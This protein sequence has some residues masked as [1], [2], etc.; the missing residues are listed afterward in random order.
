MKYLYTFII[1]L[2]ANLMFGQKLYLET[3][4]SRQSIKTWSLKNNGVVRQSDNFT[5]SGS[6]FIKSTKDSFLVFND[7]T[8]NWQYS[9]N[10]SK[11]FKAVSFESISFRYSFFS[12]DSLPD[13]FTSTFRAFDKNKNTLLLFED[14]RYASKGPLLINKTSTNL[15][16]LDDSIMREADSMEITFHYNP[17]HPYDTFERIIVIDEIYLTGVKVS[18]DE[19]IKWNF[20]IYPNPATH[21]LHFKF[22]VSIKPVEIIIADFTGRKIRSE[23]IEEKI[24]IDDLKTG[25]YFVSVRLG[26]GNT[27]TKKIEVH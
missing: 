12:S 27:F 5:F 13:F 24:N 7:I 15:S 6:T 19:R 21:E 9:F 25:L 8:N 26:D 3:F 20:E 10:L 2:Y 16:G 18:I 14:P 23:K 17:Q 22:P 11:K 4:D 1:C